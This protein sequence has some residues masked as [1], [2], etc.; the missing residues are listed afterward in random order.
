MA[1]TP[2]PKTSKI[3]KSTI[4]V[5]LENST[6]NESKVLPSHLVFDDDLDKPIYFCLESDTDKQVDL[7]N[8]LNSFYTNPQQ[9]TSKKFSITRLAEIKC[10]SYLA[11][12]SEGNW[13]RVRV[14]SVGVDQIHVFFVDFGYQDYVKESEFGERLRVLD[15][16]FTQGKYKLA[17]GALLADN[18][19]QS[20][21]IDI[22]EL[23]EKI[24][25]DVVENFFEQVID[26]R[27]FSVKIIKKLGKYRF[28]DNLIETI[29]FIF[30]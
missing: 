27:E 5:L 26:N 13:Y 24:M 7:M 16:R 14:K 29:I 20:S 23:D 4:S 17:F 9:T 22:K 3:N 12:L 2:T 10:D 19:R 8:E 1:P 30:F 28:L 15:E 6:N 18:N 21:L 25:Q 11:A